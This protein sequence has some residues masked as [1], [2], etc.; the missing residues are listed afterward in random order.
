MSKEQD[1]IDEAERQRTSALET[2]VDMLHTAL[3]N[4]VLCLGHVEAMRDAT[5]AVNSALRAAMNAQVAASPLPPDNGD[6]AVSI[7]PWKE[8]RRPDRVTYAAR[9]SDPI[10]NPQPP[11]FYRS[12]T[13][14]AAYGHPDSCL[15]ECYCYL[16]E[17]ERRRAGGR[18]K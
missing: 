14:I 11:P 12:D 7:S 9:L 8:A 15:T 6:D 2:C 13:E 10:Y 18:V 1:K 17:R 5:Q 16:C 4:G 3:S